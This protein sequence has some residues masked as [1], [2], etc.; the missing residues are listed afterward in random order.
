[1]ITSEIYWNIY[2]INYQQWID[3]LGIELD[4]QNCYELLL[5][6]IDGQLYQQ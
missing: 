6:R 4:W 1:M 5:E 2:R 3:A